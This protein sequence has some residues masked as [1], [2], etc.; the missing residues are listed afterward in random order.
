MAGNE[1]GEVA[2]GRPFGLDLS[3]AV[4]DRATRLAR[5]MFGA[6]DAQVVLV[7]DG[8]FWRSRDREGRFVRYDDPA[9]KLEVESGEGEGTLFTIRLPLGGAP[10]AAGSEASHPA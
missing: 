2:D 10:V 3:Q 6:L 8:A 4:C 9:A 7:S 5:T 1:A